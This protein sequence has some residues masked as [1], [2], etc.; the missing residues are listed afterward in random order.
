MPSV[1]IITAIWVSAGEILNIIFGDNLILY[2]VT[3]WGHRGL[4][5][6]IF[7][8]H[9]TI[10]PHSLISNGQ[11][12]GVAEIEFH[13]TYAISIISSALGLTK[14]LKNGVARP[15]APGGPL[16]GLL[17]GKFVLA[18]L[19]NTLGLVARGVCIGFTIEAPGPPVKHFTFEQ[20]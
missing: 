13:T 19:A 14:I 18:F 10:F 15:I 3:E 12:P 1:F 16:D 5:N 11:G 7:N 8:P 20:L 6:I 17:S 4:A 2:Y 9:T